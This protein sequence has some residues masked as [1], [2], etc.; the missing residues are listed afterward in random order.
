MV[1][2]VLRCA[3]ALS[4]R[5]QAAVGWSGVPDQPNSFLEELRAHL[6]RG[7]SAQVLRKP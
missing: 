1:A 5:L 2:A 7:A 3:E 4:V 6:H